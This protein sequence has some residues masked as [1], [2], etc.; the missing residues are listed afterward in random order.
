SYSLSI[1]VL[2]ESTWGFAATEKLTIEE[3]KACVGK[4]IATASENRGISKISNRY[5]YAPGSKPVLW[6]CDAIPSRYSRATL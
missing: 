3:V 6:L 4:A 5:Q 2:V 1:R